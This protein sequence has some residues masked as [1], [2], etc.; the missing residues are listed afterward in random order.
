MHGREKRGLLIHL[1]G[2]QTLVSKFC[3]ASNIDLRE[4]KAGVTQTRQ[5]LL[6]QVK[7]RKEL[8][9]SEESVR[10]YPFLQFKAFKHEEKETMTIR[11]FC[12]RTK[13]CCSGL[14]GR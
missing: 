13:S 6:K 1:P 4:K 10:L 7:A 11:T 12:K 8:S 2:Y 14:F 5:K 9:H 3:V